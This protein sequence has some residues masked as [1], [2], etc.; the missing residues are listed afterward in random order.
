MKARYPQEKS[1]KNRRPIFH[2]A[3]TISKNPNRECNE[4]R[5]EA[6][7]FRVRI[8]WMVMMKPMKASARRIMVPA[9]KIGDMSVSGYRILPRFFEEL[10]RLG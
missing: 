10:S 3:V 2:P 9:T 8:V 6:G 7:P 1:G 5:T 4:R